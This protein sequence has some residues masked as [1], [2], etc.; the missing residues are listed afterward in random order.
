MKNLAY[1]VRLTEG[2]H[3][4][5]F[6]S[7]QEPMLPFVYAAT[8]ERALSSVY[9]TIFDDLKGDIPIGSLELRVNIIEGDSD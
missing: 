7:C 9:N 1:N 8:R 6:A 3:G 2:E 5:W 4:R